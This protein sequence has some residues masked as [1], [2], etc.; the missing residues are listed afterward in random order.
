M[1]TTEKVRVETTRFG[2]VEVDPSYVIT[3]AGGIIGFENCRR[4]AVLQHDDRSPFRWLQSIDDGAVAFPVMDPQ[5]FL[6]DYN[7]PIPARDAKE[8][9]LS[10]GQR[11]LVLAIITVPRA[12]PRALTANLLGPVVINAETRAGK[13]VILDDNCRYTTRYDLLPALSSALA[14]AA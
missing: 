14:A 6:P 11:P 12:N 7:P 2:P 5:I 8:L 1:T 4:F 3:F 9:H 10:D 13:Q